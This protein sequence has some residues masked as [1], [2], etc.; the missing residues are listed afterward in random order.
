MT[1]SLPRVSYDLCGAVHDYPIST[2]APRRSILICSHPRS[3]TTML[4]E[5]LYFAGGL[6]CPL[7]YVHAGFRPGFEQRWGVSDTRHLIAAIHRH[8]T[9]PSGICSIKIFWR[10]VAELAAELAPG[11]FP[12]LLVVPASEIAPDTY[13]ALADLLRTLFPNPEFVHLER[14]D[15][16]RQALSAL[17]AAQT[18]VFRRIASPADTAPVVRVGYDFD[19]IVA[20][21]DGNAFCHAHWHRFFDAAGIARHAMTYEQLVADYTRSVADLLLWLGHPGPVP[22]VRTERQSTVESETLMLRFLRD[23]R[24]AAGG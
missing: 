10:D 18:G 20:F 22:A 21:L 5:A 9:D 14:R 8:R 15:R 23:Q 24:R 1:S 6:G 12:D 13:R 2:A 4:C 7:E 16:V 11:A 17:S 3:G 19:A